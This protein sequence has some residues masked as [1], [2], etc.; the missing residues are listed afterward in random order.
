MRCVTWFVINILNMHNIYPLNRGH[1]T[2]Y[3]LTTED[4]YLCVIKYKPGFTTLIF[5]TSD[6]LKRSFL[7]NI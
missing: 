7:N 2:T 5:T 3:T 1:L 6:N 4:K